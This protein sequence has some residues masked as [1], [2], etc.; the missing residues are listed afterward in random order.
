MPLSLKRFLSAA[1]LSA[2]G[3]ASYAGTLTNVSVTPADSTPGATTTYTFQYTLD[4][5]VN[6]DEALFY[7]TFP[8]DFTVA[9]GACD[10]IA[11]ITVTPSPGLTICR[12]SFG[13]GN[14]V[15]FAVN[16]TVSGGIS[17]PGGSIVEVVVNGVTNPSI[18]GNYYFD[19]ALGI[20]SGTGIY[21]T[22]M[23]DPMFPMAMEKDTAPQQTVTIGSVSVVNG[24]CG[25]SDSQ[26]FSAAP[27][28][29]LCATG[30]PSLVTTNATTYTWTCDGSGGGT[31]ASCSANKGYDL[32]LSISPPSGGSASCTSNPVIHG[33]NTTCTP[34]ASPGYSFVNW[35][36]DCS[37]STCVLNNV[38]SALNPQA[39][40]AL[41][42][43][44]IA[45]TVNPSTAGTISCTNNPV[46][47]GDNSTCTYTA[48][49]GYTFDNW[50][51]DCTGATCDLNGVTGAKSVTAN[52]TAPSFAITAN[53]SPVGSGTASCT[54]NPVTGGSNSTCT[55]SANSGYVFDGWTGDC[56]G[57]TCV[58]GF[59]AA[60]KTVTANFT[61]STTYNISGSASPSAGGSVSCS[62]GIASGGNGSCSATANTGYSFTGWSGC[63]SASGNSCNY[64]NVTSNQSVTANFA[65]NSFTV[66]ATANPVAG[67]SVVCNGPVNYGGSA[68]CTATPASGYKFTGW[69]GAC[70]GISCTLTNVT[71][72]AAVT[73]TFAALQNFSVTT[74]VSPTAGGT[75]NCTNPIVEGSNGTCTAKAASGYKFTGWGGDCSGTALTC[76]LAN[77]TSAKTVSATFAEAKSF[78]ISGTL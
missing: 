16:T 4:S 77:V 36:G 27:A 62:S 21:T 6:A 33:G 61:S 64:T 67:G 18:G 59:V 63:P 13:S 51:G 9:T 30:T 37:G 22:Q 45:T 35:S 32:I 14:T 42:T 39:N 25:T 20:M 15:G 28:A 44:N 43:Y 3:S 1:L 71:A 11:S 72:N 7:V 46:N 2:I 58:L 49:S 31:N 55:A 26:V 70:T 19:P 75:V 74:S 10:R 66:S 34:T 57:S 8:N 48:N 60:A 65:I 5:D 68:S 50:S 41:N 24:G 69:S 40:F 53:V 38:T 56:T 47:H 78:T 54:P 23:M 29:A 73:A 52:F 17:V 76:N 12:G